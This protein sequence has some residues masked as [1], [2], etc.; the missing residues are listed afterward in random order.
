[1]E[2]QKTDIEVEYENDGLL[3]IAVPAIG[4]FL[5]FAFLAK[6]GFEPN[7][8]WAF[9]KMLVF[10]ATWDYQLDKE[11]T[12]FLRA[13]ISIL[14]LLALIVGSVAVLTTLDFIGD[15][16]KGMKSIVLKVF[17]ILPALLY[18]AILYLTVINIIMLIIRFIFHIAIGFLAWL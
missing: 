7:E 6:I 5:L 16:F 10:P 1:M 9:I 3:A 13:G 8:V 11:F 17:F 18:K 14:S 12:H 15:F 2:K 4:I